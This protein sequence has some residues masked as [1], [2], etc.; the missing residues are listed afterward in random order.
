[1]YKNKIAQRFIINRKGYLKYETIN[2]RKHWQVCPEQA[3]EKPRTQRIDANI[4]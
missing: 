1:M 3:C 4:K 2:Y